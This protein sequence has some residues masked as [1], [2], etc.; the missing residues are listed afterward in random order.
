M[1]I[2]ITGGAG[3]IGSH[4]S[5]LMIANGHHVTIIDN[6]STGSIKN[7]QHLKTNPHFRYYI[8]TMLNEPLLAECVDEADWVFHLAA[9]VGVNLII[10]NPIH[11]I[12]TNIG[13]TEKILLYCAK[14]NKRL[15]ISSTSEVYGKST[16]DV[17]TEDDDLVF[18]STTKSRWSYATSKAI[19]EFLAFAYHKTS[20][21][22]IT[23]VRLFNTVGPRQTGQY[24]MVIPSMVTSA[25]QNNTIKVFGDGTQSRCF[26]H[27]SD[28]VGALFKLMS[29]KKTIGNV[30]NVGS[31]NE[32]TIGS[33]AEHI[34]KKLE[35]LNFNNIQIQKIPY[36]E[37]YEVGFEDMARR[38]PNLK[39]IQAAIE[40]NPSK[41]LDHILDDVIKEKMNP[42]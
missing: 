37:A 21:Q 16:K 36:S 9:A 24:G 19:D 31:Q 30:Y 42:L 33:L 12:Q 6:L 11:T 7:I 10:E 5:D 40:F 13:C 28:V 4:L 2:L 34:K 1:N 29:T 38:K 20:A 26:C 14:K 15:L 41:T 27:V 39:K 35:R 25:I 32:I 23:I 17:F 8:D 3:F 18:G 22:P